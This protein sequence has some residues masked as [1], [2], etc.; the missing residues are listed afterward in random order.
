MK[1]ILIVILAFLVAIAFAGCETYVPPTNGG[2]RPSHGNTGNGNGEADNGPEEDEGSYGPGEG[3]GGEEDIGYVFTVT[4]PDAPG[5]LPEDLEAIWT[6]N[7]AGSSEVHSARFVDGVATAEGL[8]GEYRVTLS[9]VPKF[10]NTEYTYDSNGYYANNLNR[11]VEISLEKIISVPKN[12]YSHNGSE[13]YKGYII[14]E[15]GT[16]RTTLKDEDDIVYYEFHPK[17]NGV[18]VFTSRADIV[19]NTIN[20]IAEVWD[21]TTAFLFNPHDVKSGGTSGTFTKNFKFTANFANENISSSTVKVFGVKATVNNI[22]FPITVD[23]TVE[24]AGDYEL[25][26]VTGTPYYAK[27]P[28][29]KTTESGSWQYIY[30]DNA[31][32]GSDGKTYYLQDE[33]KVVFNNTDGFYHVGTADGPLLFAKLTKCSEIVCA[34]DPLG[35]HVGTGFLWN[36]SNDGLINLICPGPNGYIDYSYMIVGAKG[37]TGYV[38][39]C[40]SDGAH[41]VNKEIKEFLQAYASKENYFR[42]GEG[43]CETPEFNANDDHIPGGLN[44][45]SDEKSMWLYDCGY[46]KK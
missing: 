17:K 16:Y 15:F 22:K 39:Y 6:K 46:Y 26:D 8:N 14:T 9:E 18:F 30:R 19:A 10:G 23:F 20:P 43:H 37:H 1:K 42:D 4:I 11:D 27:G 3:D 33:S 36:N 25:E 24:R 12:D 2:D 5:E 38:D 40:N 41:P 13:E 29:L 28:F 32:R 34:R 7:K 44:L 35:G 21:G 45:Q 31:T